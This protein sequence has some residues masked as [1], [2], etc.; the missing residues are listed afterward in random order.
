MLGR[1]TTDVRLRGQTEFAGRHTAKNGQPVVE[2]RA[3]SRRHQLHDV[4]IR[5]RPG[6]VVGLGGLLGAGRSETAKAIAG[7][8]PFDGG[9]VVVAGHP[10]RKGSP[11]AA[12]RA[13]PACCPRTA[14]PKGSCRRCRSATTSRS[15]RCRASPGPGS[16]LRRSSTG[17][18]P[19]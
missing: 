13:A 1:D 11:S 8:L 5:V 12:I 2:A 19:R 16:S 17:W 3:L 6:E 9:A 7:A 14:R 18:W 10:V 4:S 15:P